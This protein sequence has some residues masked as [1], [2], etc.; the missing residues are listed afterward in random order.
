[1]VAGMEY[2]DGELVCPFWKHRTNISTECYCGDLDDL[3][4]GGSVSAPESD[5]NM[6]CPGN[7]SYLCGA[8]NR[9]SLYKWGGTPLYTWDYASGNAAGSYEYFSPGVIVPLITSAGKNGKITFVEKVSNS[10]LPLPTTS[11]TFRV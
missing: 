5:C 3:T 6:P 7:G 11:L 10:K 4:S 8:G 9:L 2:G 1:M